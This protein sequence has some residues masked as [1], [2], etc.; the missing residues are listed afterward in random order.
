MLQ[1]VSDVHKAV[2]GM[3]LVVQ[4]QGPLLR[5]AM[6]N[7]PITALVGVAW[8]TQIYRRY[9]K[10]DLTLYTGLVDSGAILGPALALLLMAKIAR[11]NEQNQQQVA[12]P[13]PQQPAAHVQGYY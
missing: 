11:D 6:N 9:K 3:G 4:N 1:Y 10:K 5:M 2:Q 7:W 8:G 13:V 12:A